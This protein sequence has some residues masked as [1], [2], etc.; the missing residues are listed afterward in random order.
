MPPASKRKRPRIWGVWKQSPH[1]AQAGLR[2]HHSALKAVRELN[3]V[4]DLF[5]SLR[6]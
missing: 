2:W 4:T 1:G 5:H 3:G 6:E